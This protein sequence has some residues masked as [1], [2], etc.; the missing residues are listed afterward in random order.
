[1]FERHKEEDHVTPVFPMNDETCC[2]R[3]LK[4]SRM[5]E[6][7][8]ILFQISVWTRPKWRRA[9]RRPRSSPK[10]WDIIHSDISPFRWPPQWGEVCS[11]PKAAR[12]AIDFFM[13]W[14][15]PGCDATWS[16]SALQQSMAMLWCIL[17][18]ARRGG[19]SCIMCRHFW[20]ESAPSLQAFE[21]RSPH[22]EG[23]VNVNH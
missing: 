5:A 10:R 11:L 9:S 23:A 17:A 15:M 12:R 6:S 4:Y 2:L 3:I 22:L 16:V 8:C 13:P 18:C 7:R 21:G 14:S 1:M 19:Q 20:C